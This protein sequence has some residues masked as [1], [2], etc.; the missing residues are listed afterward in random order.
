MK[1]SFKAQTES[2][3]KISLFLQESGVQE[4]KVLL[5]IN[6]LVTNAILYGQATNLELAIE[7]HAQTWVVEVC[8]DGADFDISAVTAALPQTPQAGGYGIYI[9]KACVSRLTHTRYNQRNH[10]R[11]E[12]DEARQKRQKILV[13]SQHPAI[14]L[15]V[16]HILQPHYDELVFF[17][18]FTEFRHRYDQDVF[19]VLLEFSDQAGGLECIRSIRQYTRVPMVVIGTHA[20]LS[21]EAYVRALGVNGFLT[22][23]FSREQLL[24]QVRRFERQ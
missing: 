5:A 18:N 6:E 11:L 14:A 15:L 1:K 9:I 19:V 4:Q 10:T 24:S 13:S 16:R 17:E 21:A 22:N 12:F 2:L 8:D 20:E 23:P 3:H 7:H